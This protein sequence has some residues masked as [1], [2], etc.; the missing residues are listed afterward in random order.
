M[1]HKYDLINEGC[2]FRIVAAYDLELNDGTLIKKG[3]VGGLVDGEHNLSQEGRCWIHREAV[4]RGNAVVKDD[5]I[6][7]DE[8]IICGDAVVGGSAVVQNEC[9]VSGKATI[10]DNATIRGRVWV[11]G[12]AYLSGNFCASFVDN[13]N[14]RVWNYVG[15]V[16]RNLPQALE[17]RVKTMTEN[18]AKNWAKFNKEVG[19][20]GCTAHP[21][22]YAMI[23]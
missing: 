22:E 9:Q 12:E 4:V 14:L 15:R 21:V 5:A 7:K 18:E 20:T 8:A 1:A 11:Q 19:K 2:M 13:K 10:T 6:V 3:R 17:I 16:S 23:G